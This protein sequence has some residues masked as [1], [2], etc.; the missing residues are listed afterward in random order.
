MLLLPHHCKSSAARKRVV[1]FGQI[2]A[3]SEHPRSD[4]YFIIYFIIIILN[5]CAV[6][7]ELCVNVILLDSE[8][9]ILPSA[10]VSWLSAHSSGALG[11]LFLYSLL[12][13]HLPSRPTVRSS[14][15]SLPVCPLEHIMS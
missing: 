3:A 15:E 9:R 10:F 4:Y 8:T 5:V 1:S 12:I 11:G 13:S 14:N 2:K 7:G 6:A